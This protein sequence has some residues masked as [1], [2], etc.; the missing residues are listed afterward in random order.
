MHTSCQSGF[1][2]FVKKE[3][4][5]GKSENNLVTPFAK[6]LRN[7]YVLTGIISSKY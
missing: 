1:I 2:M 6:I 5:T 7:R 3:G 4:V